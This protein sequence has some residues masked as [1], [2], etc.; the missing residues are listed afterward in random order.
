MWGVRPSPS[1]APDQWTVRARVKQ[2][3]ALA[4]LHSESAHS[5]R[6]VPTCLHSYTIHAYM[7]TCLFAYL[8]SGTYCVRTPEVP[9]C[10]KHKS[11]Q[12]S[13]RSCD[14]FLSQVRAFTSGVR[15]KVIYNSSEIFQILLVIF[16]FSF[17]TITLICY[18][19]SQMYDGYKCI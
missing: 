14:H 7:H 11:Y 18:T 10:V 6:Y 2:S 1:R 16:V 5:F 9:R 15:G 8:P 17:C 3:H 4:Q 12:R 13:V 19:K